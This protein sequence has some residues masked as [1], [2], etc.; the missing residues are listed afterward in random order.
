MRATAADLDMRL[1][2]KDAAIAGSCHSCLTFTDCV[3]I[4]EKQSFSFFPANAGETALR[5]ISVV[6][7]DHCLKRVTAA[8]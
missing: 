1:P 6:L 3:L 4:V 7:F 5:R 8:I 2:A